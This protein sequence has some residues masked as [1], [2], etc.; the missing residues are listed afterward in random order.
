MPVKSPASMLK[1]AP[2]LKINEFI[3]ELG[4]MSRTGKVDDFSIRRIERDVRVMLDKKVGDPADWYMVLG[5]VAYLRGERQQAFDAIQNA[6]R[7]GPNQ[8]M[9][10]CN[11]ALVYGTMGEVRA[12]DLIVRKLISLS[13]DDKVTMGAN[14]ER[15]Y[16]LLQFELALSLQEQY[17][18]LAINDKTDGL[19]VRTSLE[20]IRPAYKE[21]A[22]PDSQLLDRLE[23]AVNAVRNSGYEVRRTSSST[24]RDGSVMLCLHVDADSDICAE[25]NFAIADALVE[26]YEDTGVALISLIT[27]RL[28]Q[29]SLAVELADMKS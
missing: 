29:F 4:E 17:D 14:V 16:G 28:S 19:S 25:L 24:L 26:N 27:R 2:A 12:S 9:I 18:K 3:D 22:M 23:T 1:P 11:A 5:I 8:M 6:L 10:L 13:L 21:F 20:Y 15:A 7:L